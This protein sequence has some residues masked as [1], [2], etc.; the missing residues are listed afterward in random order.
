M[1]RDIEVQPKCFAF[2]QLEQRIGRE[3]VFSPKLHNFSEHRFAGQHWSSH[4]FHQRDS[5]P[6]VR[7]VAI[8]TGK[9]GTRVTDRNHRS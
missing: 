4:F 1:L 3:T 6:A 9:E 7:I 5:P 2:E 8:E